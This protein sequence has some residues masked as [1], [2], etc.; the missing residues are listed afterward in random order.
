MTGPAAPT[1]TVRYDGSSRNFA[2]GNDIVVG[3]DLRADVRIAHPLISRAHL[4]LRFDRGR[5]LAIDNGSLNGMFVNGRRVPTI[6]IGDGTAVNIGNP[7]GP[8]LTFGVGRHTGT[9]GRT[10][11]TS[12]S[13]RRR[14]VPATATAPG[15]SPLRTASCTTVMVAAIFM[16][17]S[18]RPQLPCGGYRLGREGVNLAGQLK[19]GAPL[20]SARTG[21]RSRRR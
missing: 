14:R 1:L 13:Q 9:A 21:S 7:D 16:R 2:P 19:K 6:E 12:A 18:A 15:I 3:R 20:A 5:W 10:P 11:A 17:V 4:I 8:Q